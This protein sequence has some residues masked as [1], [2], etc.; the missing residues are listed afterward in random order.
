MLGVVYV[1]DEE[2]VMA[3]IPG[4]IEGAGDGKG[5]GHKFLKHLERCEVLLHLIDCSVN[6]VI[7]EYKA[8]RTELKGYSAKLDTKHEIIALNKID[9]LSKEELDEKA[10]VLSKYSGKQVLRCSGV[11]QEGIESIKAQL[12]SVLSSMKN[13]A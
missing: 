13:V 12:L 1:N 11:T 8:I 5:L 2:F 9:L 3:D 4:L 6:D 10:E 7:E